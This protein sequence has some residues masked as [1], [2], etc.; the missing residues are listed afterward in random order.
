MAS[1]LMDKKNDLE[2]YAQKNIAELLSQGKELW[3]QV[4][5][6]KKLLKK[7][8]ALI[9]KQ[10]KDWKQMDIEKLTKPLKASLEKS[11]LKPLEAANLQE[12]SQRVM[13]VLNVKAKKNGRKIKRK[14]S[15]K[16][17]KIKKTVQSK[18]K[19]TKA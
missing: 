6:D 9:G 10:I 11:C 14:V 5:P 16:A 15:S 8:E 4:I 7:Y 18:I 2:K 1:S 12:F 19:K 13:A 17:K 3:E